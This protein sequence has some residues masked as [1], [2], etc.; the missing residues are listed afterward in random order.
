[1]I[2]HHIYHQTKI[3]YECPLFTGTF[4]RQF[5]EKNLLKPKK[6]VRYIDVSA[7]NCPL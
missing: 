1:M 4:N 2:K 7:I 5:I 6:R 3:F